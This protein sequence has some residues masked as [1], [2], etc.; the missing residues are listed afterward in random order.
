[1]SCHSRHGWTNLAPAASPPSLP[2]WASSA[3]GNRLPCKRAAHSASATKNS[4]ALSTGD[5]RPHPAGMPVPDTDPL[6]FSPIHRMS[7]TSPHG[8]PAPAHPPVHRVLLTSSCFTGKGRKC[9]CAPRPQ[10]PT[11][12]ALLSP[13]SSLW[14]LHLGTPPRNTAPSVPS[15][16]RIVDPSIQNHFP[17]ELQKCCNVNK[18]PQAPTSC[19]SS[20]ALPSR[21]FLHH[22]VGTTPV[23]VINDF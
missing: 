23:K 6:T 12:P 11:L 2:R 10:L 8:P 19:S 9:P 18:T 5:P 22:P 21:L 7:L 3:R 1:M 16:L 4:T 17:P 14:T 15:P 13:G 20:H